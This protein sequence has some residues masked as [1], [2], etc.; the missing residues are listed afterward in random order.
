MPNLPLRR[1]KIDIFFAVIF[2]AFAITSVISDLLPTISVDFSPASGNFLVQG[3]YW[4]AHDADPLFMNPPVWM[5]F[6]TGLS[7]FVYGPF[8]LVLVYALLTGRNW[9][10]L[11]A[12][13]Y[14]T[15]ISVITGVIVYGVEFFGEP[16]F[17]TQNP[18]KFLAF[19][20]P[21]VVIPLILLARMRK[22]MPFTRRF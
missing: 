9:I 3:N 12:V 18:L 7:A 1:R 4:Y 17:Q 14:A 22:P 8:Y 10:Q 11:P 16:E 6:V 5:R 20:L 21:Y 2:S 15:M 13:I 19:N